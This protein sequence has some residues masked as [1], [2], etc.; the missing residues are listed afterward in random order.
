[1]SRKFIATILAA[2]IAVSGL[3]AAPAAAGNDNLEKFLIGAGTLLIIGTALEH[4]KKHGT[5]SR[6][7]SQPD[8]AHGY[9][10]HHKKKKKYRKKHRKALPGYCLRRVD[11]RHGTVRMFGK[12]CLRNNYDY[13]HR[14]PE[15]C[16]IKVRTWR[17]G[18][19]VKRVGY[20]P[21]CLR[22]Y[23]YYVAGRR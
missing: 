12:R 21:R 1:M 5:V 8:Y 15:R 7:K 18:H 20:K 22:D 17:H 10:H 14:L 16:K 19:K 4:Q 3:S 13:A 9:G 6:H 11:T 2:S 23:G